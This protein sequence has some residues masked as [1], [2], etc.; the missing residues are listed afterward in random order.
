MAEQAD[1]LS[2]LK[3]G[4]GIAG[5]LAGKGVDEVSGLFSKKDDQSRYQQSNLFWS[6]SAWKAASGLTPSLDFCEPQLGLGF[7]SSMMQRLTVSKAERLF[8]QACAHLTSMDTEQA[9][10][11]LR[12]AASQDTQF[13]DAYFLLGCTLFELGQAMEAASQFQ[14]ALLCQQGLGQKIKKYLPSFKMTLPLTPWSKVVLFADLLGVNVLLALAW[15]RAG[16]LSMAASV[17][18][19]IMSVLPD[20]P[21]A[22]FFMAVLRLELGQWAA[23]SMLLADKPVESTIQAANLILLGYAAREQGQGNGLAESFEKALQR[24]DIDRVLRY[25]LLIAQGELKAP[26]GLGDPQ[27]LL[28]R[29]Q[30]ECPEYIPLFQRLSINPLSGGGSTHQTL[31]I[32]NPTPFSPVAAPPSSPLGESLP[33]LPPHL[34]SAPKATVEINHLAPPPPAATPAPLAAAPAPPAPH[35]MASVVPPALPAP[36]PAVATPPSGLPAAPPTLPAAP[37]PA[38]PQE[39]D[40]LNLQLSC[41]RLGQ[42]YPLQKPQL[43]IGRESGDIILNFDSSISHTHA[44]LDRGRDG[45][46]YVMDLQST[47]GVFLNGHRLLANQSYPL[48][49]GDQLRVGQVLFDLI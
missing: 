31:N 5:K 41:G 40:Y 24:T 42:V 47:N 6:R 21:L 9:L 18:E 49:R 4:L 2:K 23:V 15:R 22:Q 44:R 28:G 14:K 43:I 1:I 38:A 12:Q 39:A 33:S 19:Q 29:V 30:S 17:L 37:P 45:H 35:P 7:A 48:K 25:D 46:Y 36:P 27:A 34:G 8:M 3:D 16:N 20:Q 10:D 26:L 32:S 13:T 11:N